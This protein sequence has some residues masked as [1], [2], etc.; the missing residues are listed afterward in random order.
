MLQWHGL[1]HRCLGTTRT[2]T[3]MNLVS[4]YSPVLSWWSTLL[5]MSP[6]AIIP[7]NWVSCWSGSC[8]NGT[9]QPSTQAREGRELELGL[10]FPPV[11]N[12]HTRMTQYSQAL[13]LLP[14]FSRKG[15][16]PLK[17][18]HSFPSLSGKFPHVFRPL[19][20][21]RMRPGLQWASFSSIPPSPPSNPLLPP[22][23][24]VCD[25]IYTIQH[26]LTS[27]GVLQCAMQWTWHLEEANQEEL[28]WSPG[29]MSPY[30]F[31]STLQG[32]SF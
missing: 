15:K 13:I 4:I 12:P 27:V 10:G 32:T 6:S 7:V 21:K 22:S 19:V 29:Y 26:K 30:S 16:V 14:F 24:C 9:S 20:L 1:L 28:H 23:V 25:I 8:I 31:S 5:Q 3:E 18:M 11:P 17:N 2:D